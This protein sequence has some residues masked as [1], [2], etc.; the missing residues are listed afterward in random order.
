MKL[1][2]LSYIEVEDQL[3]MTGLRHRTPSLTEPERDGGGIVPT[4]KNS[5][6]VCFRPCQVRVPPCLNEIPLSLNRVHCCLNIV[7]RCLSI[8]S[9]C[10]NIFLACLN[11]VRPCLN[12]ILIC[13]K[14]VLDKRTGLNRFS[15]MPRRIPLRMR[16]P[17][18]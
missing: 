12:K 7:R 4:A 15:G 14:V 1:S 17:V 8:V 6:T 10:L 3:N 11:E 2:F 9:C 5:G 18:H 13:L 16:Q